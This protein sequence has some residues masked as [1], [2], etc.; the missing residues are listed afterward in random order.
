MAAVGAGAGADEASVLMLR[1]SLDAQ[2]S[3]V[4]SLFQSML[5][6]PSLDPGKGR[7]VDVYA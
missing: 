2:K 6:P 5:P 4:Q 7:L 1:K 3:Q